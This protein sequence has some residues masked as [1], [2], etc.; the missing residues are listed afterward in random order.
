MLPWWLKRF[1][2]AIEIMSVACCF[3]AGVILGGCFSHL[4]PD[5]LETFEEYAS[6]QR[7]ELQVLWNYLPTNLDCVMG[8]SLDTGDS[9]FVHFV[10]FGL[11]S[12]VWGRCAPNATLHSSE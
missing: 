5:A 4:L 9:E 3:S 12:A 10:L 8:M 7:S 6:H 1:S 2:R 11:S